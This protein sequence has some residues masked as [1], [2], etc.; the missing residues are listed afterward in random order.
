[1]IYTKG[2]KTQNYNLNNYKKFNN[3]IRGECMKKYAA[4]AFTHQGRGGN[5][6]GVVL[7]ADHLTSSEKQAIAKELGYSET[8]FHIQHKDKKEEMEFYTPTKRIDFCGHA[9]VATY[10]IL[11]KKYST[12]IYTVHISGQEIKV[13]IDTDKIGLQQKLSFI[14]EVPNF[15]TL[16]SSSFSNFSLESLVDVKYINNGNSFFVIEITDWNSIKNLT[17]VHPEIE[18]VSQEYNLVGYYLTSPAEN[19]QSMTRMFAPYY[20]IPEESATGMGAGCLMAYLNK[21][22]GS[23]SHTAI[24]G[25]AMKPAQPSCLE[26]EIEKNNI[27]VFGNFQVI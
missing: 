17:P 23:A 11:S 26:L 13:K 27:W 12:G 6:A 15:K 16:L 19:Y 14:N 8:A 9:T 1:M 3:K 18:K 22:Y 10:G 5:I 4:K 20:G 24:Q 21:K 25:L 7:E 2:R